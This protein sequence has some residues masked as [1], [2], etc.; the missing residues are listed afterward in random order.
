MVISDQGRAIATAVANAGARQSLAVLSR[1]SLRTVAGMTD[2]EIDALASHLPEDVSIDEPDVSRRCV[3]V[4]LRPEGGCA[5]L[6]IR[7]IT[8]QHDTVVVR[9]HMRSVAVGGGAPYGSSATVSYGVV[10][11]DGD[12]RFAFTREVVLGQNA[13]R[14]L[15][16]R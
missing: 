11:A 9:L 16:R 1:T 4:E 13:P 5:G 10:V 14:D 7:N 12:A 8:I 2:R 3:E 6:W 15:G